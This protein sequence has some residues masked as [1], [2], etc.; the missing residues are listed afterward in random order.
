MLGGRTVHRKR[1]KIAE[2]IV[3]EAKVYLSRENVIEKL[4]LNL[5]FLKV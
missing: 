5:T 1:N 4:R 3:I 2:S